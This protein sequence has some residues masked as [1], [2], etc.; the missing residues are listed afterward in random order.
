MRRPNQRRK[1]PK[2]PRAS[3]QSRRWSS[4]VSLRSP[5]CPTASGRCTPATWPM[6]KLSR[7]TKA[8]GSPLLPTRRRPMMRSGFARPML[9][10]KPSAATTSPARASGS[11]STPTPTAPCRR[12]STS[13]AAASPSATTS[14]PSSSSTTPSPATR[15]R[16]RQAAPHRRREDLP[17]RH[18]AHRLR[19][20]SRPNPEDLRIEF[21]SAALPRAL[22]RRPTTRASWPTLE[23]AIAAV[24]SRHALDAARSSQPSSTPA[25]ASRTSQPR[26]P[27]APARAGHLP[28]HRQLAHRRRVA[29]ALDRNR[30]RRQAHLRH[31]AAADERVSRLHLHPVRRAIQRVDGRQVS[32]HE[33]RD[34]AA[35]QGRPLG[36]RRRHVGRARPQHARRRIARPPAPR[37]QALVQAGTTASTSA[38]AGT[39]TPSATTGSSRKSTR[40][41]ASTTSS[42]RR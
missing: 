34:R 35:H 37:R 25:C 6:A 31:R 39:P 1:R 26:S 22:A 20:T 17:R 19:P 24:D 10:L 23:D 7:S 16:R 42:P 27:Q 40:S 3:S 18:P 5:I 13:T 30:R 36:D 15:S 41:P 38:S 2:L 33:R 21:L 8:P 9:S 11:S 28:P 29:L 32:R 12:S 14:S 4:P